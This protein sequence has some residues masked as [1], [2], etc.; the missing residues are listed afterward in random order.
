MFHF[1][2]KRFCVRL[3]AEMP[4]DALMKQ[5][6]GAYTDTFDWPQPGS[7]SD[8]DEMEETEGKFVIIKFNCAD[9]FFG[10]GF[11]RPFVNDEIPTYLHLIFIF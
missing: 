5:Y 10:G 2:K 11:S 6:A 7:H 9:N 8:E 3:A 4:L 1:F